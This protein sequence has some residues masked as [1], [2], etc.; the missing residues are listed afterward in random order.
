LKLLIKRQDGVVGLDKI[1]YDWAP[2]QKRYMSYV[3]KAKQ[4]KN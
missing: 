1:V 2:L 4:K 3:G